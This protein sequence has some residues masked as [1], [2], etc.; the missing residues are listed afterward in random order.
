MF[1]HAPLYNSIHP[2]EMEINLQKMACGCPCGGVI[3]KRKRSHTQSSHLMECIFHWT[4]AC[5]GWPP[6]CS[7]GECYNNGNKAQFYRELQVVFKLK[8]KKQIQFRVYSCINICCTIAI[9]KTRGLVNEE[10]AD[11]RIHFMLQLWN[12]FRPFLGATSAGGSSFAVHHCVITWKHM[13]L[14]E[15]RLLSVTCV[16]VASPL[17]IGWTG[18]KNSSTLPRPRCTCVTSVESTSLLQVSL[19]ICEQARWARSAGNS[20]IENVCIIITIA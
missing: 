11:D 10:A 1:N 12:A 6:E 13:Q 14:G 15:A 16:V 19:H 17:S 5:T 3:K 20:A 9:T 8:T 2:P 7:T 18:T 4:V